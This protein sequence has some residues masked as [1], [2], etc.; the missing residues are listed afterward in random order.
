MARDLARV[1]NTVRMQLAAL[2]SDYC[3]LCIPLLTEGG[4]HELVDRV[5]VVDCAEQTQIARVRAR[6]DLTDAQVMAIMRTQAS[7][8]ARLANADDVIV[9]DGDRAALLARI[10]TLHARY[11]ALARQH[12]R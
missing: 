8:A 4:R 7:R 10:D 1:E 5:L 6:D 12:P 2:A 11:A 9:N 3:L